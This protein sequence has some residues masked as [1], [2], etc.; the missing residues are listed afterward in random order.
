MV[1]HCR[2]IPPG[3][4]MPARRRH[5][6]GRAFRIRI[7]NPPGVGLR[8]CRHAY[9]HAA[10]EAAIRG[11]LDQGYGL[12]AGQV[13]GQ[14]F[15]QRR[16]SVAAAILANDDFEIPMGAARQG[17][18]ASRNIIWVAVADNGHRDMRAHDAKPPPVYPDEILANL[19]AACI[20]DIQPL[21]YRP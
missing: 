11:R 18:D 3:P 19:A 14:G 6:A 13:G 10:G 2:W 7:E 5:G 12:A 1:R 17:S 16:E 20:S 21:G 9:I 15:A 4:A 8:R